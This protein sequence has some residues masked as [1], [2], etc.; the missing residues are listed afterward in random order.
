MARAACRLCRAGSRRPAALVPL[1]PRRVAQ[2]SAALAR[3]AAAALALTSDLPRGRSSGQPPGSGWAVNGPRVRGGGSMLSG[4]ASAPGIFPSGWYQVAVTAPGYNVTGV[5][6][7]GLPGVLIGHNKR[8]AWT[9]SG[10]QSQSALFYAEQM[11]RSH[12]GD[13]LWRGQWRPVRLVRYVIPVRGGTTRRLTVALTAHGPLLAWPGRTRPA[14]SVDWMG[15]GG[16][17]DIAVLA[18][19]GAAANFSQ[20]HAALAGWR[21]PAA[22]FVYADRRGNIGAATAGSFPVVRSGAP[23]LPLPGTGRSDVAGL[24]PFA[25]LPVSYDPPGHVVVAAGQRPVTSAYPYYL[26]TSANDLD[27]ADLAGTGYAVLGRK[28]GLQPAA[29]VP[30]QTSPVSE[31]AAQVVPRLLAALRH[32]SLTSAEQQARSALRGW[33]HQLAP[34]SA[35]AA[36]WSAFWQDYVSATFGP[37]WRAASVPVGADPAGLQV[38]AAQTGLVRALEHWTLAGKPDPVFTPPGAPAGSARSAMR[39]AF[40]AAVAQLTAQFGGGRGVCWLAA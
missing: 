37:W 14:I 38:S 29:V 11:S 22:T 15:S 40:G 27:A 24:I 28:S 25:A 39:G 7:P 20:F 12:P 9:L 10:T 16:S 1:V 32:A 23:W 17:P 21:S 8:I 13:Y 2:P 26:G 30:L 18:R 6:L 31:L 34:A 3:S 19:I 5:S 33:N 35:A 36:I 4:T